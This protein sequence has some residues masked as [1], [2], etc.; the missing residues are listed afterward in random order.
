MAIKI[1]IDQGHNP[2]NPNAGAE[3]NGYREQN[4]VFNIGLALADLL[5]QNGNFEVRLSRPTAGTQ[6]GTSNSSSLRL[7]VEDA[8]SWGANYFISLHTNASTI[9]TANGTEGYAFSRA[10]QGFILGEYILIGISQIT[11]LRNRGMQVRPTLYVL[12]RTEMPSMLIELGFISNPYEANLMAN[13]P[14]LFAQGIYNGMLEY[15]GLS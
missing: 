14:Y 2:V 8:N 3:G 12:K 10:S 9:P 5:S 11:G 7:R 13:Q 15:F 6:L 4:I 1:Y